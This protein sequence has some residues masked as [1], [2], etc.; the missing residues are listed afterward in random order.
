MGTACN[1]V[2]RED[3][4]Q[5][6]LWVTHPG[7]PIAEGL[8]PCIILPHTEMYGEP[9]GIPVPDEQVFISHFAGG[10]VFRSG[11]VWRRGAG[12][13]FYFRPGHETYPIY[14]DPRIL[15]VL[16]NAARYLAP[17]APPIRDDTS[18]HVPPDWFRQTGA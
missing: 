6:I 4:Q 9:F 13:V 14:H 18:P 1:H 8:G 10:E 11:N 17:A 3:G 15:R 2:W 5:E 12:R 16:T 7:H